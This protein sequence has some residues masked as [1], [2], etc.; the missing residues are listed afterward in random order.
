MYTILLD[1]TILGIS[2]TG[3][4]IQQNARQHYYAAQYSFGIVPGANFRNFR[5]PHGLYQ[6]RILGFFFSGALHPKHVAVLTVNLSMAPEV[7]A[8]T[9]TVLV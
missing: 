3:S 4:K 1:V 7:G 5:K 8:A 2:D 9:V 6:N